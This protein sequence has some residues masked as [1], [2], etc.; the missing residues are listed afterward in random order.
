VSRRGGHDPARYGS[1][2][3]VT[4]ETFDA[5][6]IERS[7]DVPV[8]ADFWADWCGPC[9]ALA[10]VLEREVGAREGAVQLVKIDVDANQQLAQRF[11]VSGIPAVKAFRD[12]RVV[13]EFTGAMSPAS[14]S[15]FLDELLAPPRADA[16]VDELRASGELPDV[17]AALDAGD[18][19]RALALI[20]AAVPEGSAEDRERLREVAVAL[21][22]RLGH[23]DPLTVD[24]RRR[25]AAALY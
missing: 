8:V 4:E 3:D 25:L 6:V 19:E 16:V 1:G 23:E 20:L 18:T 13:S 11:N 14:V 15:A 21:F 9:H 22:D 7:R 5:D 10:P 24:Y 12:G 17:L 2:V